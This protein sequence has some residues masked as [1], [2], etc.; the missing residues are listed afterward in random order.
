M[1]YSQKIA[2]VG[3]IGAGKSIV[4]HI[5]RLLN[6]PVYDSDREAKRLIRT[7]LFI[8]RELIALVGP[9]VY[10]NDELCK[11]VLAQYLFSSSEYATKI[12]KIVHPRVRLDFRRWVEKF[13]DSVKLVALE[14]ALLYE[15]ELDKEV[16]SVWLVTAPESIRLQRAIMRDK[17]SERSIYERMDKQASEEY[18]VAH[19]DRVVLK[20]G[21]HAV[22]P[23]IFTYLS[24]E[25]A[26]IQP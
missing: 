17:A 7:D 24:L 9:E 3:G 14:T 10:E 6:I 23:Q 4:S 25:S 18:L 16:D 1:K 19:A 12:N 8:R 22:L 11:P 13:D 5:F 20:D 21:F 2:L 15:S 26:T